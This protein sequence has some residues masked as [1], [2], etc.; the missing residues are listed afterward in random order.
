MFRDLM[1]PVAAQHPIPTKSTTSSVRVAQR[2]L[3]SMLYARIDEPIA[4]I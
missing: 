4:P 2:A 3:K 1:V